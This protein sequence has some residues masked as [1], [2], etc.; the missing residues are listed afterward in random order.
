MCGWDILVFYFVGIDKVAGLSE[1]SYGAINVFALVK[2][3]KYL[4]VAKCVSRVYSIHEY[5]DEEAMLLITLYE[6]L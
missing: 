1:H 2:A 6:D 3:K 4:V 5:K